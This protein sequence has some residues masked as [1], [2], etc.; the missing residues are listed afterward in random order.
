MKTWAE[1][2]FQK[3]DIVKYEYIGASISAGRAGRVFRGEGSITGRE[4]ANGTIMYVVDKE[5]L[6]FENELTL[7]KRHKNKKATKG[8]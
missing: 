3:G 4:R 6:L 5:R 2:K 7:K 8:A 1:M